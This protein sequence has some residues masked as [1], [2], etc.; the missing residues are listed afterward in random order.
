MFPKKLLASIL[1]FVLF[2][3]LAG[4]KP[5]NKQAE[6]SDSIPTTSETESEKSTSVPYTVRVSVDKLY[7][8]MGPG[9][10]YEKNGYIDDN[11]VYTIVEETITND[12][13]WGK[14]KSGQGWINLE[15]C[16]SGSTT[17]SPT[18][19]STSKPTPKNEPLHFGITIQDFVKNYNANNSDYPYEIANV[20]YEVE[21]YGYGWLIKIW[22]NDNVFAKR[23]VG[24]FESIEKLAD[25][26]NPL[27]NKKKLN[28]LKYYKSGFRIY[29]CS[30]GIKMPT[31]IELPH[32]EALSIV[33]EQLK[34]S[35]RL[36]VTKKFDDTL[37]TIQGKT[38]E[39]Y[40]IKNN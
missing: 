37:K 17:A 34:P 12:E 10:D 25:Y 11:G 22:G 2:I 16:E 24:G 33:G 28:R 30:R 7:I 5:S 35:E 40:R 15:Y 14:L 18:Q 31:I 1:V 36:C 38:T 9:T 8:R 19:K 32:N 13:K 3:S 27:M 20:Q 29:R 6:K 21:H 4:C 23:I 39:Y 26:F